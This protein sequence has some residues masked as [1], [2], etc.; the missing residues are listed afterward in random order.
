[1]GI[2]IISFYIKYDGNDVEVKKQIQVN[3]EGNL[4][5]LANC[6]PS[7]RENKYGRIILTFPYCHLNQHLELIFRL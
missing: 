5:I 6:L 1:M 7:M 3:I 2:I 4:N